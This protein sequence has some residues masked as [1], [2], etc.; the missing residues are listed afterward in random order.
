MRY[1]ILSLAIH[2][3]IFLNISSDSQ[4]ESLPASTEKNIYYETPSEIKVKLKGDVKLVESECPD[5]Y[6]GIG[7]QVWHG[8][9]TNVA[10][11][12]PADQAGIKVNDVWLDSDI[13][14]YEKDE[15][16]YLTIRT[17]SGILRKLSIKVDRIC[18]SEVI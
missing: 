3:T 12:G 5:F 6:Y 7:I 11:G 4:S 8:W 16:V 9:I 18:V 14:T 2:A 15:I 17:Q 1:L 10:A 13:R